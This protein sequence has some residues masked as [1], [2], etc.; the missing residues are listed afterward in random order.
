MSEQKCKIVDMN[1]GGV[2][3]F[4][5]RAFESALIQAD[6]Y[7]KSGKTSG[8]HLRLYYKTSKNYTSKYSPLWVYIKEVQ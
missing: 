3:F 1:G 6:K 2:R 8:R 4:V 5:D 7:M